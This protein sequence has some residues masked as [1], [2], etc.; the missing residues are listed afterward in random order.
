MFENYKYNIKEFIQQCKECIE[1]PERLLCVIIIV[2]LF[3]GFV[4][5]IVLLREMLLKHK[6]EAIE[7]TSFREYMIIDGGCILVPDKEDESVFSNVQGS[8]L[9][10]LREREE[11]KDLSDEDLKDRIV[12]YCKYVDKEYGTEVKCVEEHI[13]RDYGKLLS[14]ELL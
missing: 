5:L 11:A 9:H 1:N 3:I 4:V 10:F 12:A 6:R 13:G 2:L 8:L 14:G 7:N